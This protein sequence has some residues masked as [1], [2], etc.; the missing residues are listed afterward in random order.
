MTI[1]IGRTSCRTLFT[2]GMAV[3]TSVPDSRTEKTMPVVT[4]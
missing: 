1:T 4:R 2:H 3:S